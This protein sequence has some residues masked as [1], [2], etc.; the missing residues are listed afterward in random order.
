MRKK[1]PMTRLA[2][3]RGSRVSQIALNSSCERVC[4]TKHAPGGPFRL[5]ERRHGLAEIVERRA[6]VAEHLPVIQPHTKTE[7]I[8]FPENA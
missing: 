3:E 5:L 7:F 8:T 2:G 6:V 1:N 4:A